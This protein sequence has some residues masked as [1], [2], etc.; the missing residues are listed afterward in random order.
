MDPESFYNNFAK[1]ALVSIK[2]VTL[3]LHMT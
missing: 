2:I 3:K 1:I